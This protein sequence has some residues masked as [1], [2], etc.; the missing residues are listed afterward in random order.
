MGVFG[1][2]RELQLVAH[3]DFMSQPA[4]G[5]QMRA[6]GLASPVQ[7]HGG[8]APIRGVVGDASLADDLAFAATH[9]QFEMLWPEADPDGPRG[10]GYVCRD[11]AFRVDMSDALGIEFSG[12]QIA[13]ADELS[14]G[15]VDGAVQDFS[16]RSDLGEAALEEDRHPVAVPALPGTK[17]ALHDAPAN[18]LANPGNRAFVAETGPQHSDGVARASG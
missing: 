3:P 13:H 18:T 1:S 15:E 9:I 14:C 5:N 11:P 4:P 10:L 2:D 16:R 6:Q 12:N 8:E 7:T 17:S